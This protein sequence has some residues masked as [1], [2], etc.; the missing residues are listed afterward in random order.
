MD[1][2][3]INL[4]RVAV[5]IGIL[6]L[7]FVIMD[8]NSRLDN[9]NRLKKQDAILQA[10]ATQGMQTHSALEAQATYAASDQ[11]V[12]DWARQEGRYA[13]PGDQSI[14]P[15]GSTGDVPSRPSTP[16]PSPTPMSNWQ[17]WWELFFGSQ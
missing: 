12:Q 11:A 7:I 15:V 5:F 8:F 1:R 9:L 17:I 3:P 6:L 13:Q 4:R 16:T 14:I 2:I 10:E